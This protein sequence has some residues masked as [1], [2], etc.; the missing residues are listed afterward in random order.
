MTTTGPQMDRSELLSPVPNSIKF[1][2]CAL[3]SPRVIFSDIASPLPRKEE[4]P[5]DSF[6]LPLPIEEVRAAVLV[7]RRRQTKFVMY[8]IAVLVVLLFLGLVYFDPINMSKGKNMYNVSMPQFMVVMGSIST[9]LV[10]L[11]LWLAWRWMRKEDI[12]EKL[13][14]VSLA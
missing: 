9:L 12:Y 6:Q 1:E 7:K 2:H 10:V 14:T 11:L 5:N 4:E 13:D 3:Q 8:G